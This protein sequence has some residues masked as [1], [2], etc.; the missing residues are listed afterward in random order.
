MPLPTVG[1]FQLITPA[2]NDLRNKR[3]VLGHYGQNF[4]KIL[5]QKLSSNR[6][7]K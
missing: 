2:R 5:V 6:A 7:P 4:L 1:K 3:I